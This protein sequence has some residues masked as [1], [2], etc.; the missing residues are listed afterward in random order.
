MPETRIDV[1]AEALVV[2]YLSQVAEVVDLVGAN[3]VAT[4]LPRDWGP[5]PDSEPARLRVT[6][7]GG[8]ASDPAGHL[9][10]ARLQIDAFAGDDGAAYLLAATALRA[11]RDLPSSGWRFPGAVVN[12]VRQD[13]GATRRDDPSSSVS[14]YLF[15]VILTVHAAPV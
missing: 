9:V 8:A 7:I 12:A 14:S 6:R 3:G 11:L 2:A 5:A 1:D 15:G 13:L 10:P 4:D